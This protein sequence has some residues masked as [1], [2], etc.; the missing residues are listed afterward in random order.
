MK[1]MYTANP[2]QRKLPKISLACGLIL[3]LTACAVGPDYVRPEAA[4]VS[5]FTREQDPVS[6]SSVDLVKHPIQADWWRDYQS[7]ALNDIVELALKHNPNVEAAEATLKVTRANVRAQQGFFFPAITAGFSGVRGNTGNNITAPTVNWDANTY[8]YSLQTATFNVGFTPDI[9]GLNRRQVESLEAQSKNAQYQL[10]ALK[11]TIASNVI[12]AVIQE[13]A[14]AEQYAA[15]QELVR[16]GSMQLVTARKML[17]LGYF[18]RLDL[19]NQEM[20]YA[21]SVQGSLAVKKLLDQTRDL[22]AVLC[23]QLPST[24]LKLVN[25]EKVQI[26]AHLPQ[27]VPS[28]LVDQRPDVMAAEALVKSANAQIGVAI[29]NM[30]PQFSIVGS[31]GGAANVWSDLF[32]SGNPFWSLTGNVGQVVFDGGTLYNRKRAA[33]AATEQAVAQYRATVIVAYQ[34]VADTLYALEADKTAFDTALENEKANLAIANGLQQQFEKGYASEPAAQL[35]RQGYLSARTAR[36]QAQATYLGDTV[37]LYQSLGGGW[38]RDSS[39]S[40]HTTTN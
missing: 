32:S 38:S 29:A 26:P 8:S 37:A 2:F 22:I 25:L 11:I 4:S 3:A 33:E 27:A 10:D 17:S 20:A 6:A 15:Q 5:R 34:N 1:E 36:L 31:L 39:E 13:A 7:D 35:A 21:A 16:L 23:G 30:L 24:E 40:Q 12:A 18:S 19:A 14:L 9:F 28:Q